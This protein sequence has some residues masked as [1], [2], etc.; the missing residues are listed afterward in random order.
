MR[1]KLLILAAAGLLA[2]GIVIHHSKHCPLMEA[3]K[4]FTYQAK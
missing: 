1:T 4:A 2:T 3:K